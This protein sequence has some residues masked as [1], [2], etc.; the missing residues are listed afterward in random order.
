M[1]SPF[2]RAFSSRSPLNEIKIS[3]KELN[4]PKS[5]SPEPASQLD[6]TEGQG[7]YDYE[8]SKGEMNFPGD[9][10]YDTL[11]NSMDSPKKKLKA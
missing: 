9:D 3:Q 11:E 7:G 4:N 10:G 8:K 1:S 6:N 2:Q 5:A